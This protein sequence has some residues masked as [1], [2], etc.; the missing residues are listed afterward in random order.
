M[1]GRAEE[2]TMIDTDASVA[3]VTPSSTFDRLPPGI[4]NPHATDLDRLAASLDYLTVC[5]CK[6]ATGHAGQHSAAEAV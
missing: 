2:I 3:T 1:D 5:H 4:S 6:P